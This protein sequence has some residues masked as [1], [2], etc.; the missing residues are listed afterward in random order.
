MAT[1]NDIR[2]F[3]FLATDTQQSFFVVFL[4][5]MSHTACKRLLY[6]FFLND[7]LTYRARNLLF[8]IVRSTVLHKPRI[9]ADLTEGQ[10]VA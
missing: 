2:G 3:H 10:E 1:L 9:A 4:H 6:V 5:I 8:R 7:L